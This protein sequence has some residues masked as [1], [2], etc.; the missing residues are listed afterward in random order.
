MLFTAASE[1]RKRFKDA[2]IWYLPLD[3]DRYTKA[4]QEK[5][6]FMFLL[7]GFDLKS[8]VYEILP[9]LAA[10]IDVSGYAPVSYTHLSLIII[11]NLHILSI[12]FAFS[13]KI[14][15]KMGIYR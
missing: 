11:A 4:V 15:I 5:Y 8:Q 10:I 1:L 7:D 9:Q 12:F 13:W 2:I 3:A 14:I 6:D